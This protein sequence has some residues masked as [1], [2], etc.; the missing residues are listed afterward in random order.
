MTVW[1]TVEEKEDKVTRTLLYTHRETEIYIYLPHTYTYKHELR[2]TSQPPLQDAIVSPYP[3][4][5][6]HF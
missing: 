2:H 4:T 5:D 3:K 1:E 6:A